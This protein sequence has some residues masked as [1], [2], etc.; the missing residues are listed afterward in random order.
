MRE[1]RT[2]RGSTA[3]AILLIAVLALAVILPMFA[4]MD[5]VDNA[6]EVA[7]KRNVDC[8]CHRH[9]EVAVARCAARETVPLAAAR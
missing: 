9:T 3:G 5:L 2:G 6:P 4:T 1:H 8:D 7:P